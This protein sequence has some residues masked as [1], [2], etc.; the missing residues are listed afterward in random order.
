MKRRRRRKTRRSISLDFQTLE[1][2]Q[3]LAADLSG[4]QFLQANDPLPLQK[5]LVVNGAFD[6]TST[7]SSQFYR[8][9][10][11]DGWFGV[12]SATGQRLNLL[13]VAGDHGFVLDL[14]S[15]RNAFD[16]VAQDIN[17]R[18]GADY[19]LAFD[20]RTRPVNASA[21]PQTNDVEV[22]WGGTSLGTFSAARHWQ[23]V[24]L[25]VKGASTDTTRLE[26]RETTTAG[27]D[28]RGPLID[29]VRLT[30]VLPDAIDNG[31]FESVEDSALELHDTRTVPGWAAMGDANDRLLKIVRGSDSRDGERFL[32][33]DSS[34]DRLDRIYRDLATQ[35][36][37]TYFVTFD[38]KSGTG[39]ADVE[40]ELRVRWAGAWVGTF[41]GQKD[42]QSFGIQ[43]TATSSQSRL[44]FREPPVGAQGAGNGDGPWLDN[45]RVFRVDPDAGILEVDLNGGQPG[46]DA[47]ADYTEGSGAIV[48][49]GDQ[50]VVD[51][52][53]GTEL[54][55]ATVRILN[56]RD[57]NQESLFATLGGTNISAA[58]D[59]ATGVLTLSG[60]DSV[61][62]YQQ[63][64]RTVTYNNQSANP[65]LESRQIE[66]VVQNGS[67]T[68]KPAIVTV[69]MH[70]T[71]TA[72]VIDTIGDPTVSLGKSLDLQIGVTDP[73][74]ASDTLDYSITF[75]GPPVGGGSAVPTISS[76]GKIQWTPDREGTLNVTVTVKDPSGASD[77]KTFT[78]TVV[79]NAE[80]PADF[81]PFSGKRQL[82]LVTP[83][84]RNNIY[85]AKPPQTLDTTKDYFAIFTTADGQIR[86]KLF[87]DSAPGTVNNFVAL[88]QD[89]F[90]DGLTFHRVIDLGPGFIAQGGDPTG[91]GSGGPGYRFND[92]ATALTDFN[93]AGLLAMANA[94]PDTNGSQFF[95]TMAPQLHLNGLH[96]IF[97]E[98]VEGMDVVN[99]INQ[100]SPG[101]S[102]PAE[103]IYRVDIEV[104]DP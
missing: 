104:V 37:D 87:D 40:N 99:A 74:D 82:S 72:P 41:Q 31:S 19:I 58:F 79:R 56:P 35:N 97:G 76:T 101:S 27:G 1:P 92:E 36:G 91:S 12:N 68:S 5:N 86:V 34:G 53:T 16:V 80:V 26:F 14:D 60:T 3:L 25:A 100:R 20:M 77:S 6:P 46:I 24:V 10:E 8:D 15:T 73:D 39:N 51:N 78:V 83:S 29:N 81:S 49:T 55:G 18:T 52:A 43:V 93:R 38:L 23:S 65:D 95:F 90:Y 2:R 71:N 28:G 13:E 22:F 64:L 17:T 33:L 45:V 57:G 32:N 66:F 89:G 9:S 42:W 47:T 67:V 69:A 30:R 48:I 61:E 102:T 44:I 96:A 59:L 85:S 103:I 88:A 21:D 62:N 75:D 84:A 7:H 70:R 94:G 54:T 11:V 4:P 63:V 98:V 50:V